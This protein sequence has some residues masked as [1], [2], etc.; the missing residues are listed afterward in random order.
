MPLQNLDISDQIAIEATVSIEQKILLRK[1]DRDVYFIYG[2]GNFE[3][4]TTIFLFNSIFNHT[5]GVMYHLLIEE[6]HHCL[7]E[8]LR[9]TYPIRTKYRCSN[10]PWVISET[11]NVLKRL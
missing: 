4:K 7:N 11:S 1:L 9:K 3:K 8:K 10:Y 5:A 2:K 6:W